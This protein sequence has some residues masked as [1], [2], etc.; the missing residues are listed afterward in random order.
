MN[1]DALD[2]ALLKIG[3]MIEGSCFFSRVV[4]IYDIL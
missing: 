4:T 2:L 3:G 1:L